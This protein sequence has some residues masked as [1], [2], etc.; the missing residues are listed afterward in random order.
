MERKTPAIW[1]VGGVNRVLDLNMSAKNQVLVLLHDSTGWVSAGDLFGCIQYSNGSIFRSSVLKPL[2][3]DRFIE[4]DA[5]QDR[6]QISPRGAREV[7]EKLL[8]PAGA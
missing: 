6:A 1:K 8:K 2:H 5:D 7:E 4:F 3:T